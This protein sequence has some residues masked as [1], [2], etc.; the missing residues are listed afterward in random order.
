MGLPVDGENM[1]K[2]GHLIA[3]YAGP[4]QNDEEIEIESEQGWE[5]IAGRYLIIQM[6]KTASPNFLNLQEVTAFGKNA[7]STPASDGKCM[8][9]YGSQCDFPRSTSFGIQY[10]CH[11]LMDRYS[12]LSMPWCYTKEGYLDECDPSDVDCPF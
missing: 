12:W 4:G 11:F 2:S 5:N 6:D 7:T 3:T 10:D 8:G 9:K 1:F